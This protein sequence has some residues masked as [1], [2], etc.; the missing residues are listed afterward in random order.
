MPWCW[1]RPSLRSV[2]SLRLQRFAMRTVLLPGLLLVPSS[3]DDPE[4][5]RPLSEYPFALATR[6]CGP[7]D[8]PAM[9][10]Y[11]TPTEATDL[12]VVPYFQFYLMRSPAELEGR[13]WVWPSADETVAAWECTVTGGACAESPAGAIALG[14][15]A[16]DSAIAVV[17]DLRRQNGERVRAHATARWLGREV[18]CG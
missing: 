14:R 6:S 7:A 5:P 16:V 4:S 18:I 2:R 1:I 8:G 15:F 3:C 9:A 17:V 12:P 13:T 10:I 11:L